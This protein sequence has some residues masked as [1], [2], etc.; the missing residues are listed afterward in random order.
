MDEG[1]VWRVDNGEKI[2]IWHDQWLLDAS[3]LRPEIL[4]LISLYQLMWLI[5]LSMRQGLGTWMKFEDGFLWRILIVS[6]KF[7][8][9]EDHL[10]IVGFG[11]SM[12]MVL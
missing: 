12:R 11:K 9:L 10:V 1:Y 5:L 2:H 8:Y 7:I 3:N 4:Q 6:N